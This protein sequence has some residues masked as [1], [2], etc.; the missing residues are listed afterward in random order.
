MQ[1]VVLTSDGGLRT[2]SGGAV[3][4]AASDATPLFK[5]SGVGGALGAGTVSLIEYSSNGVSFIVNVP[6]SPPAV[7]TPTT[8]CLFITGQPSTRNISAC[9]SPKNAAAAAWLAEGNGWIA[10]TNSVVQLM[11]DA[12]LPTSG[13]LHFSIVVST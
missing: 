12:T 1:A 3:N 9:I 8:V 5:Y 2:A 4:I 6:G 10:T 11:T 13:V 7:S